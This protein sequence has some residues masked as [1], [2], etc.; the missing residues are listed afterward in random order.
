MLKTWKTAAAAVAL[1]LVTAAATPAARAAEALKLEIGYIPILAAA[2]LFVLEGEGWAKKEGFELKLTRF[3]SGPAGIQALAA[4]KIDMLYAGVAPVIVAKSKGVDV[5]VVAN[6]GME[7]MTVVSRGPLAD[8]SDGV[9]AADAFKAFFAKNGRKAKI[10]TQPPG[11]V[12]NTTLQHWLTK[13]AKVDP[14]LV[15]I[16][17]MGIEK[18]QQALMAGALDAA[19]IREPT[20]TIVRQ[21]DPKSAIMALGGDMFPQQPGTVVAAHGTVIKNHPDALTRLIALHVKAVDT[22]TSNPKR[23]AELA[24]EY[25]GKGL[26]EPAVLESAIASPAS[27]FD[28]D[29]HT[30]LEP[31]RKMQAYQEELGTAEPGIAVD[32]AFD[33]R[34]YDAAVKK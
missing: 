8:A 2:P 11:S 21:A 7:E 29:P 28:A 14:A 27:K 26:V 18:T 13:M 3:E 25:L 34:F 24:N 4:G 19:T 10:G 1:A 30:I 9:P 22:V 16:V 6:S 12:P 20:V 17:P 31:A 32:Q 15:E 33:F 23:T 5:A